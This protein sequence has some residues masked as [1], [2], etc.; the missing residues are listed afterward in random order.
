M[1]GHGPPPNPNRRRRN[2]APSL[3][4]LPA[5][6]RKGRTPPFPIPNNANEALAALEET[7]WAEVWRLPQAVMWE[8][9]SCAREVALY[10][11]HRAKAETGSLDHAK[12]ARMMADRLGLTPMAMKHLLWTVRPDELAEKRTER[13]QSSRDR[14]KAVDRA[15]AGG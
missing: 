1:A 13:S 10:V 6:G 7:I 3:T 8:R 12:E 11:R 4:E 5:E 14:V 9:M 2:A 15:V